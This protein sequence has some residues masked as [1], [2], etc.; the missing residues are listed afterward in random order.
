MSRL[1][2][3]I[4]I[5]ICL[6]LIAAMALMPSTVSAVPQQPM[7]FSGDV[8]I[9]GAEAPDGVNVSAK[10]DGITYSRTTTFTSASRVFS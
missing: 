10:I 7:R 5:L 3:V 2:R 8:T 1:R 6:S 9:A 4:S